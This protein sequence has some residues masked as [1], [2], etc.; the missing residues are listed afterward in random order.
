M[1]N[2][3]LEN[4]NPKFIN[5]K[6]YKTA[7]EYKNAFFIE[8]IVNT[9]EYYELSIL[10]AYFIHPFLSIKTIFEA[11]KQLS[12]NNNSEITYRKVNDWNTKGVFEDERTSNIQ[13]RKYSIR[14]GVQLLLIND[15]KKCGYSNA[16]I[17]LI[18]EV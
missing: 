16:Q 13:W 12:N 10:N 11:S 3:D 6:D 4:F 17:K 18:K 7:K 2:A 5:I 1:N 14:T 9:S 15:L 8:N